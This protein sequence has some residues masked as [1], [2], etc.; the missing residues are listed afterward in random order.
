MVYAGMQ[1]ETG[2]QD[3]AFI[4]CKTGKSKAVKYNVITDWVMR[5][6]DAERPT[7]N[8][9]KSLSHLLQNT[10][11]CFLNSTVTNTTVIVYILKV[12]L[13]ICTSDIWKVFDCRTVSRLCP[14]CCHYFKTAPHALLSHGVKISYHSRNSRQG[15]QNWWPE[16][17]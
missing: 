10:N 8:S 16:R 13:S 9:I 1:T 7:P 5:F 14:V 12:P 11:S 4:A 2:S 15:D 3:R 6:E 17:M